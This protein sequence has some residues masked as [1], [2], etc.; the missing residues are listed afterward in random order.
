MES[1]T[2]TLKNSAN[3]LKSI[4]PI[5][6]CRLCLFQNKDNIEIVGSSKKSTD[7]IDKIS[8]HL[9][10]MVSA[11]DESSIWICKFCKE[12]VESFD[13]FSCTVFQIQEHLKSLLTT[14]E[15]EMSTP[16]VLDADL[17]ESTLGFK[18]GKKVH[19]KKS[20][21]PSTRSRVAKHKNVKASKIEIDSQCK[22]SDANH[23]NDCKRNDTV[24]IK[25][26]NDVTESSDTIII[27]TETTEESAVSDT[28]I[29]PTPNTLCKDDD[30]SSLEDQDWV[31]QG[32]NFD[33]DSD[34]DHTWKPPQSVRS[35]KAIKRKNTN[36]ET[37]KAVDDL[38]ENSSFFENENSALE[39]DKRKAKIRITATH[40]TEPKPKTPPGLRKMLRLEMHTKFVE[41][42]GITCD[43]CVK[44]YR[45]NALPEEPL[46]YQSFDD[47]SEHM[48][49]EHNERGYVK[50]CNSTMRD[51]KRAERHMLLHTQPGSIFKCNICGKQLSSHQSFRSHILLHLPDSERP[52][53][54]NQCERGFVTKSDLSNHERQHL[55]D[56]QR[57]SLTCDICGS[58]FCYDAA[59]A[60][61][62]QRVHENYRPHLCDLCPKSFKSRSDLDRHK[63]Q[64][65]GN[66][67]RVQCLEC[68]KW[69]FKG[70]SILKTHMRQHKGQIFKC[71][72]C[73]KTYS[74][75]SSWK[76][77]LVNHSDEKPHKC[78]VCE[79]SFKLPGTLKMHLNQHTGELPYACQFCPKRFASSGNYYTHRKRMHQEQLA[80]IKEATEVALASGLP[81]P[82]SLP[83]ARTESISEA[84]ARTK[85][86]VAAKEK[87]VSVVSNVNAT[88]NVT[89]TSP[90]TI[91]LDVTPSS[92]I[93]STTST[94][95]IG[96]T[97]SPTIVRGQVASG[98][99]ILN[100]NQLGKM[101]FSTAMPLA[102]NS[103]NSGNT[104]IHIIPGLKNV[105]APGLKIL[106]IVSPDGASKLVFVKHDQIQTGN[107]QLEKVMEANPQNQELCADSLPENVEPGSVK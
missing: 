68:G 40:G 87:D 104:P 21:T 26:V 63:E 85:V 8:K 107:A 92:I 48:Q 57:Y 69:L 59:L 34:D 36:S 65:H 98:G 90:T 51:R 4:L 13:R 74:V 66:V 70:P 84:I 43:L 46:K 103:L 76:A 44:K 89:E 22:E 6:T 60:L 86:A 16:I 47:L 25:N 9:S 19:S 38:L 45:E 54:C 18:R 20:V 37:N 28:G 67:K 75:R 41:F 82:A 96:V 93:S 88:P 14:D 23:I 71:Q 100:Q 17:I 1:E 50:C 83:P 27:K 102:V 42:Y 77:H 78:P 3:R 56:D 33:I 52:Y 106:R 97:G 99:V 2:E 32:F 11:A 10:I 24:P 91:P 35:S 30:S 49:K 15:D 39:P 62:K 101:N 95:L 64:I 7:L 5:S 81:P 31:G 58:R 55:P 53:Q 29:N 12:T 80:Q 79:K 94:N 72:F 73:D 105:I 61:H